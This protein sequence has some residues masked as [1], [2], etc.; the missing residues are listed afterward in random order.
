[1]A[2]ARMPRSSFW[3][4]FQAGT[5][6]NPGFKVTAPLAAAG[7]R[8]EPPIS[9]PCASAPI[10]AITAAPAPPDEP[11][12]DKCLPH[13]L[14]VRPKRG[15]CV[16]ARNE[17]SGVLVRPIITAPAFLRFS[18]TGASACA[19]MSLN[20]TTPLLVAQSS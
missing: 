9:L 8:S 15:F 5:R 3:L 18:T 4:A 14:C 20:A 12:A 7:K 13:G 1:M 10:P 19:M 16:S 2:C 6:P 17:N 11:P